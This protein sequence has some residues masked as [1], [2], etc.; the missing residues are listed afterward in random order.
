MRRPRRASAPRAPARER[1]A[2]QKAAPVPAEK[3]AEKLKPWLTRSRM[4]RPR[5]RP[6]LRPRRDAADAAA[7]E[8]QGRPPGSKNASGAGKENAKVAS[9]EAKKAAAAKRRRRRLPRSPA[10]G[11]GSRKGDGDGE[12]RRRR[13]GRPSSAPQRS[14]PWT[15]T[16]LARIRAQARGRAPR[17]APGEGCAL[18]A[19][20][21]ARRPI[22]PTSSPTSAASPIDGPRTAR[23]PP[24]VTRAAAARK[25]RPTGE[26][27]P[28]R[29]CGW[30]VRRYGGGGGGG[31]GCC[32]KRRGIAREKLG[33]GARR[34]RGRA[35]TAPCR[36]RT[37]SSRPS[38]RSLRRRS[39]RV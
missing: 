38:T 37:S 15:R 17:Q 8:A 29:V 6:R 9:K 16:P 27:E 4:T 33:A 25:T 30:S 2:K 20:D 19:T 5:R 13:R 34:G 26:V 3:L 23:A 11:K 7:P 21:A 22:R 1:K 18:L 12:S 35:R 28:G 36:R 14:S 39:F 10:S 24:R 31:G 32:E